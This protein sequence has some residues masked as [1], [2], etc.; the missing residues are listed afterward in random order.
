[1]MG[2]TVRSRPGQQV[3]CADAWRRGH[4]LQLV[5]PVCRAS[6]ASCPSRESQGRSAAQTPGRRQGLSRRT[7][8]AGS[9][10]VRVARYTAWHRALQR[11]SV[12]KGFASCQ[13]A[14]EASDLDLTGSWQGLMQAS[15]AAV[16]R[17]QASKAA[18]SRLHAPGP[19]PEGCA[20]IQ[21]PLGVQVQEA[22]QQLTGL[23]TETSISEVS[24]QLGRPPRLGIVEAAAQLPQSVLL[25]LHCW[26]T[27]CV[28]C[29]VH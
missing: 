2:H 24:L 5:G 4:W 11:M 29:I 21:A 23:I 9:F 16:G 18:V 6:G 25:P 19:H 22:A 28:A 10:Q 20:C 27:K 14:V 13:I 26:L 15:K 12:C 7:C 1:M 3:P 17:L 8:A